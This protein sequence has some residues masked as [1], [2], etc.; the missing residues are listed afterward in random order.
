MKS[1][2]I[3]CWSLIVLGWAS[4]IIKPNYKTIST[5]SVLAKL[6]EEFQE[7][8]LTVKT[9][10][11]DENQDGMEDKARLKRQTKSKILDGKI[12]LLK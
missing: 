10:S 11:G 2:I 1:I 9:D 8:C 12:R 4:P 6:W 7:S 3:I 5:M